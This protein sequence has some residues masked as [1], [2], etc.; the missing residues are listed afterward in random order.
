MWWLPNGNRKEEGRRFIVVDLGAYKVKVYVLGESIKPIVVPSRGF[1]KGY[2]DDRYAL[3][4]VM[5]G[6]FQKLKNSYDKDISGSTLFVNVSFG[7]LQFLKEK[8]EISCSPEVT[9]GHIERINRALKETVKNRE[10]KEIIFSRIV[11]YSILSMDNQER[12]VVNPVGLNARTLKAEAVFA[13]ISES[14]FLDL[15]KVIDT[16]KSLFGFSDVR[17]YDSSIMATYGIR[18]VE[19]LE[20]FIN[21]DIGHT[22]IR[23]I[24]VKGGEVVDLK[25]L[26]GGGGSIINVMSSLRIPTTGV[27]SVLKEIFVD[28]KKSVMIGS[29]YIS[30]SVVSEH[31]TNYLRNTFSNIT[32]S[33]SLPITLCGGFINLGQGFRDLVEV[34]LHREVILPSQDT[35]NLISHG[36]NVFVHERGNEDLSFGGGSALSKGV[37]LSRFVGLVKKFINK[38]ILGKEG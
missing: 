2:V 32:L 33:S 8:S 18:E 10:S 9:P 5:S 4:N 22:G 1:S 34:V 30:S 11:H 20:N 3:F 35:I 12:D 31:I 38:E 37:S 14:I 19:S 27:E 29:G 17:I 16:L 15:V 7:K 13:V 21:V 24:T 28:Q 6:A 25:T 23:I 26:A 36:V